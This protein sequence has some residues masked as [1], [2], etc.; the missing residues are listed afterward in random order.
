MLQPYLSIILCHMLSCVFDN[1]FDNKRMMMMMMMMMIE[2]IGVKWSHFFTNVS[3]TVIVYV[4]KPHINNK[5]SVLRSV[6]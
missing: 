2:K 3:T 5:G 4:F 1:L 6:I